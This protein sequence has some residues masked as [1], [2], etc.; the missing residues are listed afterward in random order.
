MLNNFLNDKKFFTTMIRLA[1]PI[2]L[3]NLIFSSLG[4]VDGLMIGQLGE[5]AVAAIGVANS[6]PRYLSLNIGDKKISNVF[7][8]SWD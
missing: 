4:L 5:G 8:V 6:L 7:K 1:S 3:Q 2:M